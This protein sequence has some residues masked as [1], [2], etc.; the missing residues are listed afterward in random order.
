MKNGIDRKIIKTVFAGTCFMYRIVYILH[1]IVVSIWSLLIY[2]RARLLLM[3]DSIEYIQTV[4]LLLIMSS[5]LI[6]NKEGHKNPYGKNVL[7]K[8]S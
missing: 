4:G 6:A 3:Y 8:N 2:T 1:F 5:A 7:V